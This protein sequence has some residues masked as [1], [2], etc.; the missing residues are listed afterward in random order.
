MV[1]V[2]IFEEAVLHLASHVVVVEV[3]SVSACKVEEAS[4]VT[5]VLAAAVL[6][7]CRGGV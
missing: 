1:V 5:F 2:I 7:V 4:S 3:L 6:S